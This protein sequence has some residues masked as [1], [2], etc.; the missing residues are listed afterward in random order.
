M[1]DRSKITNGPGTR[2]RESPWPTSWS[3]R[4]SHAARRE[5]ARPIALVR[6]G[7]RFENAKLVERPDDKTGADAA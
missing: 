3:R 6:S 4:R 7:A 5:R 2:P 1:H